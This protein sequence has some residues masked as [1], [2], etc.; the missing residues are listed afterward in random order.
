[1]LVDMSDT[2]KPKKPTCPDCGNA[3]V[4]HFIEKTNI[5][6]HYLL[7]PINMK[8]DAGWRWMEPVLGP[9]LTNHLLPAM[10][11]LFV[12]L[13]IGTRANDP[14]EHT[15]GRAKVFW[16][17]AKRR[18]IDMW[19]F[20]LFNIGREVFV[21]TWKGQHRA[22]DGLP[23]PGVRSSPSLM[24]MDN[25]GIMRDRFTAAG[26]PVARGG[27]SGTWRK[28]K[29]IFETLEKPVIIKPNLG[30]RSRHTTTHIDTVEELKRAYELA[31]QLSHWVVIEEEHK[32]L[33]Y[34]ATVVDGKLEGVLRREPPCVYGDGI[35]TISELIE[36]ENQNPMRKGPIFHEIHISDLTHAELE[37]QHLTL[38][39]IPEQ[40]KLVTLA[41]KASRG[42]GGG[43]TDVTDETHPDN[44]VLFEYVAE[45]LQDPL[46]GI[47]FMIDDI[48]KSWKTEKRS[49]VIECNS[50]PFID[51]HL[52][53]LR[54]KP[55]NISAALWDAIWPDSKP[56]KS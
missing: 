29:K 49:G 28:T 41:Q 5:Y 32:G 51:L 44:K 48:S 6:V 24:W 46:V 55:R 7:D 4:N 30:S 36:I 38:S 2:T 27:V 50:L 17:E 47:D 35:H 3:P 56:A 19:E 1:M 22:F 39:D 14:D 10:L 53:P 20:R 37:K 25:K 40:G 33:V 18:G 11:R 43:A 45:V 52:F 23:R 21:A 12:V 15:G 26:I 54:G 42:L 8:M 9:F 34:R 16:E 31:K 13:H